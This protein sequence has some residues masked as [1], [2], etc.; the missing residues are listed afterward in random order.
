MNEKNE[1]KNEDKNPKSFKVVLM[2]ESGVGKTSIINRYVKNIFAENIISTAGVCFSSKLIN[3]KD[4]NQN[5]KLDVK[6][7]FI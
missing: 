3:V 5:C 7:N 4:L 6:Y 1:E 2:G